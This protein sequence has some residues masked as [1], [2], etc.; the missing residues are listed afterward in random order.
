MRAAENET[1]LAARLTKLWH[2]LNMKH[3]PNDLLFST[4]LQAFRH[5]ST[6]TRTNLYII[7][8]DILRQDA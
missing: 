2:L 5:S 4:Q 1:V 3:I 7:V 8:G 6:T